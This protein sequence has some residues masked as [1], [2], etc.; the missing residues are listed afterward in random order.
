MKLRKYEADAS[1]LDRA[2][3]HTFEVWARD[4]DDAW[5]LADGYARCWFPTAEVTEIRDTG[6]SGDGDDSEVS[7]EVHVCDQRRAYLA[8]F[9]TEDQALAFIEHRGMTHAVCE[10][11]AKP[12]SYAAFP[13]LYDLLYP[14]C[15]HGLSASL[16][17]GPQH[18]PMDM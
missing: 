15:E 9:A 2:F 6:I 13:R 3:T 16:C 14:T 17:E 1:E 5:S 7:L 4:A 10:V 8:T 12:F 11:Q 18:Y